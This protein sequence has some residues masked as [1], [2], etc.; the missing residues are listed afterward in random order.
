MKI[1]LMILIN[2]YKEIIKFKANYLMKNYTK[3]M[4]KFQIQLNKI[5]LN[6]NYHILM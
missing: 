5:N 3:H 6:D 4:L 2:K 1:N